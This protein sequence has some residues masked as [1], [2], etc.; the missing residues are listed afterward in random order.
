MVFKFIKYLILAITTFMSM[1]IISMRVASDMPI[2]SEYLPLI[3]LY[4]MLGMFYTFLAFNWFVAA[5]FCRTK[6]YLPKFLKI[7]LNFING[8]RRNKVSTQEIKNEI[9]E[10]VGI[11]NNLTFAFMFVTMFVTYLTIWLIITTVSTKNR[12]FNKNIYPFL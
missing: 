2:H 8:F 1:G 6:N 5:N 3:S 7:S 9:E 12:F 10:L 4:F 11:L